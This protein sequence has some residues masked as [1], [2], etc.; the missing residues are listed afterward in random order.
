MQVSIGREQARRWRLESTMSLKMFV[1]GAICCCC[2]ACHRAIDENATAVSDPTTSNASDPSETDQTQNRPTSSRVW[3]DIGADGTVKGTFGESKTPRTGSLKEIVDGLRALPALRSLEV[4]ANWTD[5]TRGDYSQLA[6]LTQL[7]EIFIHTHD[8]VYG[9]ELSPLA[10]LPRLKR[11][12]FEEANVEFGAIK[13]VAEFASLEV[14]L[15][16]FA[17][18]AS[19]DE[20]RRLRPEMVFGGTQNYA[21]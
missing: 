17:D 2:A 9:P 14:F 13:I 12:E 11:L 3:I 4:W 16:P 6:R 15:I 21:P 18:E 19:V 8:Q 7:E 20:M 10:R 1:A 5:L